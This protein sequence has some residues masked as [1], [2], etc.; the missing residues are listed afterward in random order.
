MDLFEDAVIILSCGRVKTELFENADATASIYNVSGH[1]Q[2]S[3]GIVQGHLD[4]LFSFVDVQT[5]KFECNR[6]FVQTGITKMRFLKCMDTCGRG[7]NLPRNI[8]FIFDS[9]N[10]RQEHQ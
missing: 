2:G 4:F 7:L 8:V 9:I 6:V 1:A 3:L 5:A 10:V